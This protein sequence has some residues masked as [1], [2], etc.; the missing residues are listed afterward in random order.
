MSVWLWPACE[1]GGG[2][3]PSFPRR[4]EIRDSNIPP[5]LLGNLITRGTNTTPLRFEIMS[6]GREKG[7]SFPGFLLLDTQLRLTLQVQCPICDR[8]VPSSEINLHL[9]LQCPGPGSPSQPTS[10]KS[11]SPHPSSTPTLPSRSQAPTQG[12]APSRSPVKDELEVVVVDETPARPSARGRLSGA[13]R[14][15]VAPIFAGRKRVKEEEQ[16][17]DLGRTAEEA[18]RS[19]RSLG[20]LTSAAVVENGPT[21]KRQRIN[22]VVAA[23]PWVSQYLT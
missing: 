15:A 2:E 12:R 17:H 5:S 22:P 14:G 21:E 20:G 16:N 3:S 19:R 13:D 4:E 23:Q 8:S 18:G 6:V 7:E 1:P 9:D 11:R 10:A